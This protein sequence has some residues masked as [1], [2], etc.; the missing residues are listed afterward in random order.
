MRRGGAF[1]SMCSAALAAA[2]IG[3]SAAVVIG[4]VGAPWADAA[5]PTPTVG[6]PVNTTFKA[7]NQ[8]E[9]AIAV[10]PTRPQNLVVGVNDDTT[11]PNG[12]YL[13][14][15]GDGGA[16]WTQG[17]IGT[18]ASGDGFVRSLGDPTLAFDTYGNLFVGYIGWPAAGQFS[19]ELLMSTDDGQT[20][21]SLGPLD[22]CLDTNVCEDQPTVTTGPGPSGGTQVWVTWRDPW[23][24]VAKGLPVSGL[25]TVGPLGGTYVMTMYDG[26]FGDIAIGPSGQVTVAYESPSGGQGPA[27]IYTTTDPDGTGPALFTTPTVATTTNVGG[28][29]FIPAQPDRSVDAEAGLVYDR[30]GDGFGGRLYLVYTEETVNESNDTDILVRSSDNNGSSWSLPVKVN[31]DGTNRSQFLPKIA[32]DQTTGY[33]GVSWEDARLDDGSGPNANDLNGVPNNDANVYAA[34]SS[35][36]GASFG[37]NVRVS[38]G[39]SNQNGAEPPGP[40][41]VD[42]DYGDY[43]GAAFQSGN[44]F[45]SWSDNSN[46][47]ADNPDGAGGHWDTYA[48]RIHFGPNLPPAVSAGPNASGLEGS[49]IALAGSVVDPD[50]DATLAHWSA[51]GGPAGASCSFA[52]AFNPSTTITCTDNGTYTATLAAS[53]GVNPAVSDSTT[54]TV[55]NAKPSVVITSPSSGTSVPLATPVNL[56]ASFTDAANDSHTC[57][58]DWN[59]G[60]VTAGSVTESGGN[61][62][63]SGTHTYSGHGSF[64]VTATVTDD[65]GGSGSAS[66]AVSVN[67]PPQ[68]NAGPAALGSEGQA[69]ALAGTATDPDGDT[70]TISWSATP[71]AGVDAGATCSFSPPASASTSI[72]CTDDGP[73]TA[74]LTAS[75]GVNPAV[76]SST[77]VA[78]GNVAASAAVSAPAEGSLYKVSSTV[79]V[80]VAFADPATNDTHTCSI[81]WDDGTTSAGSVTEA[82]GT[83]TCAGSRTFTAAG[84]YSVLATVTDDDGGAA[85][86]PV[87]VVVYDPSAGYVTGGGTIA[88]PAGAYLYDAAAVGVADFGFVSKYPKKA[89]IPSGDTEFQFNAVRLEFHSLSYK[90]LVVSGAKA[91]YKG[92]GALNGVSGYGFLLTAT[93][94][95]LTGGGG[96]DRFRIKIWNQATGVVVYD[97]VRGASDDI[98]SANPEAISSGSIVIHK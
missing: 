52:N 1:H 17:V 89:S 91:Q 47:T 3:G 6:A 88:S 14:R 5:T 81:A 71:G 11:I 87:M 23:D 51:T 62:T 73:W 83:G 64:N 55:S 22:T 2:L 18:G 15:S 70:L 54:V 85:T 26:N 76:S 40:C 57:S 49:A 33:V 32:V 41:C 37:A 30:S 35:D 25:G 27:S 31:D 94:G 96:V 10:D 8:S 7:G 84:V 16:T 82:G 86:A 46:S 9:S 43:T 12:M 53:D 29:D 36:N 92:T 93:D 68:V 45:P 67:A 95:N 59:D 39:A 48:A 74:T 58:I 4:A 63:C 34:F 20:F 72:T 56:S 97:N 19:I 69:V 50:G 65:D 44:F 38:Q 60:S 13:G 90:W 42:I 98:D 66:V 75:D 24:L 77:A 21:S 78:L 80:T 79:A 61:G 28:F